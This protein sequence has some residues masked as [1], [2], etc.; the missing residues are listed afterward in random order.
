MDSSPDTTSARADRIEQLEAKVAELTAAL[1]STGVL[2]SSAAAE[3]EQTSSRR[4]MLKLAGAAAAGTVAAVAFRPSAAAADDPND[5]TLGATK[6]TAALTTGNVTTAAAGG[7]GFLFQSGAVFP[8]SAASFPCALAGWTTTTQQPTGIYGYTSSASGGFGV[9]AIGAGS[10]STGLIVTGV[11]STMALTPLGA[12]GPARTVAYSRGEVIIDSAGDLWLNVVAGTPGTWRKLSGPTTAG[13]YHAIT[14]GRV[15]DSRVAEPAGLVGTLGNLQNRTISLA[16]K[17]DPVTGNVVTA[18]FVPAGATAVTAN[19][20]VVN[21]TGS[22][23]LTVNPGGIITTDTAAINWSGTGQIL[24]NG[25]NLTL[26]ATRQVTV[27]CGGGG[28]TDF[29][30]DVSGYYL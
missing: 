3:P 7:A 26:N 27:I 19:L 10:S 5:L 8:A 21:T 29:V 9:A 4:G 24:N 25:L 2:Q 6:A 17:R 15:Y 16:D 12:A 1:T 14:P 18:N 28:S 23:F 11:K 22:G 30:I 13:A 20:T